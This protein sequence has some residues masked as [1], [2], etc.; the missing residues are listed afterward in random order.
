MSPPVCSPVLLP[1]PIGAIA[2]ILGP[3]SLF[4]FFFIFKVVLSGPLFDFFWIPAPLPFALNTFGV[5]VAPER[6]RVIV[7]KMTALA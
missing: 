5:V 3:R 1:G 4:V 2:L 7:P 6:I